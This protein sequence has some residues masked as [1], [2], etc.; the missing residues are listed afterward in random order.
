MP[1]LSVASHNYKYAPHSST[2][3]G[4]ASRPTA[5]V[6]CL[7]RGQCEQVLLWIRQDHL[8]HIS[9]SL[10]SLVKRRKFFWLFFPTEGMKTAA[11]GRLARGKSQ[12]FMSQ[13]PYF[14]LFPRLVSHLVIHFLHRF[15]QPCWL[16]IF[17]Y[18]H[19]SRRS[20]WD[21]CGTLL[22]SVILLEEGFFSSV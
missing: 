4:F 8:S 13:S 3:S 15:W 2:A 21:T 14:M 20:V 5:G 18:I 16:Q 12:M 22:S 19:W 9:C 1:Q 7:Y 17:L 10:E 11:T 6:P